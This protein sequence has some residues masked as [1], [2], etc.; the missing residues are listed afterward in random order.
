M[1]HLRSKDWNYYSEP[2]I[3]GQRCYARRGSGF[4]L[5]KGSMQT[6]HM[7][8]DD[9]NERKQQTVQAKRF[10]TTCSTI[11]PTACSGGP[12]NTTNHSELRSSSHSSEVN[13]GLRHEG[14]FET[15]RGSGAPAKLAGAV[16]DTLSADLRIESNLLRTECTLLY[17]RWFHVLRCQKEGAGLMYV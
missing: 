1:L 7:T 15:V 13:C 9:S 16:L 6:G 17:V 12:I 14:A 3:P 11:P 5:R 4:G 8:E 2:I 10:S